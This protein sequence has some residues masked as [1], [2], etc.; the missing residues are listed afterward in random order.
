MIPFFS[1]ISKT[2]YSQ[3]QFHKVQKNTM[4]RNYQIKPILS[5]STACQLY[6]KSNP[7]SQ[8][9]NVWSS[10]SSNH[11]KCTLDLS[12]SDLPTVRM[13]NVQTN[14]LRKYCKPHQKTKLCW[15]TGNNR[16]L[17]LKLHFDLF[18]TLQMR[19]RG[20]KKCAWFWTSWEKTVFMR[21]Y[22]QW[23]TS[24]ARKRCVGRPFRQKD[25]WSQ[26]S[27]WHLSLTISYL[28]IERYWVLDVIN[29]FF[30]IANCRK[31]D[32][33]ILCV[34][35]QAY[36]TVYIQNILKPRRASSSSFRGEGIFMTFHS[37]TSSCLFNRGTRLSSLRNISEFENFSVLIKMQTKRSGQSKN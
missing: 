17:E 22:S 13:Q 26:F 31:S 35:H 32:F 5:C 29:R 23:E 4:F 24:L 28:C 37:I 33:H 8:I 6:C 20:E 27:S 7:S 19:E 2:H 15:Q 36:A 18:S 25:V 30:Y 1:L 9:E 3:P 12:Y 14:V 34:F 11:W 21:N 16:L 10:E